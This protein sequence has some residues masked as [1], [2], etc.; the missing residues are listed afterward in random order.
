MFTTNARNLIKGACKL[1]GA[2]AQGEVPTA[3]E[4]QDAF[5]ILNVMIDEWA[6]QPWTS[7]TWPR[8]TFAWPSSTASRTIGATGNFTSIARPERMMQAGF[9]L[10]SSPTVEIPI[11]NLRFEQYAALPIKS[12]TSTQPTSLYYDPTAPNGTLY[13]WPIPTATITLVLYTEAPLAQFTDLTTTTTFPPGYANALKYGLWSL[14][15]PE[16]GMP[17]DPDIAALGTL[18]LKRLKRANLR[19]STM[20]NAWNAAMGSGGVYDILSDTVR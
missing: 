5:A 10:A 16:W 4:E 1:G 13:L 20:P 9:I 17:L 14:L 11:D 12:L 2:L 6:T 18:Y 15:A 8:T 7:Y 19:V 3:A